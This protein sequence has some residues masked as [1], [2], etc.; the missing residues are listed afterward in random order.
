[1]TD[2]PEADLKLRDLL[3]ENYRLARE[4]IVLQVSPL[5]RERVLDRLRYL[6]VPEPAYRLVDAAPIERPLMERGLSPQAVLALTAPWLT[7]PGPDH[8]EASNRCCDQAD[9]MLNRYRHNDPAAA[10]RIRAERAAR[11]ASKPVTDGP[12]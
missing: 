1:M 8:Y 11:K 9:A 2:I 12:A 6:S 5:D 7:N 3:L 10:A 4:P